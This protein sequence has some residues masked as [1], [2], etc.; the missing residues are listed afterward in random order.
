MVKQL[1]RI[2]EIRDAEVKEEKKVREEKEVKE[3]ERVKEEKEVKEEGGATRL[4]RAS[5]TMTTED[6][7]KPK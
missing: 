4:M 3:E 6:Q 1:L 7:L 2:L 5:S